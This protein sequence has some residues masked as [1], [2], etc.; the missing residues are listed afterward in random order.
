MAQIGGANRAGE[1]AV[2]VQVVEH[3]SLTRRRA[4][5]APVALGGQQADR[6]ARGSARRAAAAA[7]HAARRA[8]AEG[9][10]FYE[11][12]REILD[13]IDAAEELVGAGRLRPRGT[14]RVSLSHG[15]GMSQIVPLVPEFS[16]RYPE[17]ELQLAF[18]DR[19]LDLVGRGHRPRH[20]PRPGPRRIADRPPSRPTMAASSAP[21][22]PISSATAP[23]PPRGARRATTASCSTSPT[24]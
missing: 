3:G 22:P 19:R 18:A 11:R 16:A 6:P 14:L 1:M 15:F 4:E 13:E 9:R 12:A 21:P 10:L 24:I 23:R 5:P 7:D 17:V 8:T 2:F 20:P